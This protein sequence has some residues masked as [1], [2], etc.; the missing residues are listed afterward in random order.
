MLGRRIFHL[1][2]LRKA[3]PD[4]LPTVEVSIRNIKG[5]PVTILLPIAERGEMINQRSSGDAERACYQG[6]IHGS[7]FRC[8]R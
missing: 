3:R 6:F 4:V 2:K 5:L 7:D 8:V 1:E